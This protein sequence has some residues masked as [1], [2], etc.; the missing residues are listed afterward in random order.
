MVGGP[1]PSSQRTEPPRTLHRFL[2]V[3]SHLAKG[4]STG[5]DGGG[6]M[7]ALRGHWHESSDASARV[8]LQR[9]PEGSGGER[10]I[11]VL[12]VDDDQ[13]LRELLRLY[14]D[15]SSRC[16]VVGEGGDGDEAIRL[17]DDLDPDVVV[18]DITMPG[19]SGLDALPSVRRVAPRARILIYTSRAPVD[20]RLA[21]DRGADDFCRKGESLK[22]VVERVITLA[23]R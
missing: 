19:V 10:P 6:G 8:A 9:R 20:C 2:T 3:L 1:T 11:R 22:A 18:L 15:R 14:L 16:E 4:N 23:D 13:C 5:I 17:A 7:I 12:I 21:F